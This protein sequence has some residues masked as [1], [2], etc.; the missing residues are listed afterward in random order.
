[1]LEL[2]VRALEIRHGRERRAVDHRLCGR[3]RC[4]VERCEPAHE[5]VNERVELVVGQRP[6][7]PAPSLGDVRRVILA[8]ED[9]L[10]GT[11]APNGARQALGPSATRHDRGT[12]LRLTEERFLQRRVTQVESQSELVPA[13][14][15]AAADGPDSDKRRRS[16]LD[17]YVR[18]RVLSAGVR[19]RE[20]VELREVEVVDEE[21][22]HVAAEHHDPECGI[23]VELVD[24][25]DQRGDGLADDQVDRWVG[26]RHGGDGG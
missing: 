21:V 1:V 26:E 14:T 2:P 19:R 10:Q 25:R 6:R 11:I 13:T 24:D 3:K 20:L 9:D 7:D 23:R 5:L 12:H 18:P 4:G 22:G 17:H 16:Q 15:G 8:R